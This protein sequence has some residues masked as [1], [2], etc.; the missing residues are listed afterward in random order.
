MKSIKIA[1]FVAKIDPTRTNPWL[2]DELCE[3]FENNENSIDVIFIDWNNAF[4]PGVVINNKNTRIHIISPAGA[5]LGKGIVSKV[6]KWGFS[7]YY[8]YRYFKKHFENKSHDLLIS[9]SPAV[10]FAFP[11][12]LLPSHFRFRLF[13]LWDFFPY[14]QNQ[15]GLIPFKWMASLG[16]YI[17]T[18]LLSKFNYIG[19]MTEKNV[20]YLI[21]HYKLASTV[22]TGVIPLW[23]KIRPQPIINRQQLRAKYQLPSDM[24]VAVFGG[25]IAA[26]RG[27]EDIVAMAKMARDE[28]HLVHF[29]V[30]GTGPKLAWL[31]SEAAHLKEFISVLPQVP[32]DQYVELIASCDIGLVMT[33]PNVDVPSFPSKT[34]DYCCVGIPILA[35]VE[36][37]T[38]YGQIINSSEFGEYCEA[39]NPAG[40]YRLIHKLSLDI[41]KRK[42]MGSNARKYYE[43]NFD[44]KKIVLKI[45]EMVNQ[46][47]VSTD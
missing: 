34:L 46:A 28:S 1:V 31:K 45:S 26:G 6:L 37:S 15:I 19:C 35:A 38:D 22:K 13:V 9:F 17:E 33:V 40:F 23:A 42:K 39:G 36:H 16:V 11:I 25:Q 2:T 41:S 20:K 32:R 30:I 14:H 10:I 21:N 12:L 5:A 29:L 44:V 18:K 47:H 43:I 24:T 3:A 7:S 27:I 8:V 4:Q